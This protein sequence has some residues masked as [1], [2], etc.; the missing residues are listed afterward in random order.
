M[1]AKLQILP[2]I[3]IFSWR[4]AHGGLPVGKRSRDTGLSDG[5]CS[6]C[7]LEE[8]TVV[9][10][11]RDCSY[12][13]ET[14]ICASMQGTFLSSQLV[15]SLDWNSKVHDN[16]LQPP[17][18]LS[19]NATS[20]HHDYLLAR[21]HV[22]RRARAVRSSPGA[23]S[24]IDQAKWQPPLQVVVGVITKNVIGQVLGGM[25][26]SSPGC[27]E[28]GLS[29]IHALNAALSLEVEYRWMHVI[30]ESDSTLVVNKMSGSEEDLST[31]GY[32]LWEACRI[33]DANLNYKVCF[34]PRTC[35]IVAHSLAK[36]ALRSGNALYFDSVCPEIITSV[37]SN[38]FSGNSMS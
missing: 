34:V 1:V 10:I 15:S 36:L 29:G 4:V 26:A 2:K 37:V 22:P 20:L 23:A 31:L 13:Q 32:H 33:L 17:W 5:L 18:I 19:I 24:C 9:H 14:F 21:E 27:V 8:E 16:K 25:T 7:G 11:L 30:F 3:K 35:N 6:M 28:A 12:A 38:D